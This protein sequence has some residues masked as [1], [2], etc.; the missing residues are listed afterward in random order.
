[1]TVFFSIKNTGIIKIKK[2]PAGYHIVG[3]LFKYKCNNE[4]RI[5]SYKF[6]HDLLFTIIISLWIYNF[7]SS[8]F[9]TLLNIIYHNIY[10]NTKHPANWIFKPGPIFAIIMYMW[11]YHC[12]SKS[13]CSQRGIWSIFWMHTVGGA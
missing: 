2:L 3:R 6:K 10:V 5:P 7:Q 8:W 4:I 1:M 9:Q 13:L 11:L 12:Y